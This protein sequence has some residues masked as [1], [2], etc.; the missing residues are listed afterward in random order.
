MKP[1]K[2]DLVTRW[3]NN[4]PQ[5]VYTDGKW[6]RYKNGILV[7]VESDLIKKEILSVLE[8]ARKDGIRVD[9]QLL[10]SIY[11]LAKK[12]ARD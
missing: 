2:A 6:K 8:T 7:E 12:H 10:N 9:L 4:N 1:N 3:I 5:T 11:S